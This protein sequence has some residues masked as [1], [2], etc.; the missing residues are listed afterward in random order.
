MTPRLVSLSLRL[1]LGIASPMWSAPDYL[2][3]A[4]PFLRS[5]HAIPCAVYD[6]CSSPWRDI[7]RIRM[8]Y[9]CLHT[10]GIRC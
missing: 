8:L 10:A 1:L 2:Y 4:L 9:L 5:W 7:H 3:F 6:R